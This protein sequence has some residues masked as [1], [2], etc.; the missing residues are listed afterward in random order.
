MRERHDKPA[1]FLSKA[2]DTH[3][4]IAPLCVACQL[5]KLTQCNTST[6][7]SQ[8]LVT[9]SNAIHN[10]NDLFPGSRISIDQYQ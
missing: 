6:S 1:H 5:A 9:A 7:T 3:N 4:C 10:S 8:K 2:A